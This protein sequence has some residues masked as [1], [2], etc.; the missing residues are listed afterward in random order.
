[1]R[2]S[3]REAPRAH[4]RATLF[5]VPLLRRVRRQFRPIGGSHRGARNP[6]TTAIRDWGKSR[7]KMLLF[8]TVAKIC[9]PCLPG[10]FEAAILIPNWDRRDKSERPDTVRQVGSQIEKKQ[11]GPKTGEPSMAASE[12]VHS[13]DTLQISSHPL[14]S[15]RRGRCEPANS[16]APTICSVLR[17]N[18]TPSRKSGAP[19]AHWRWRR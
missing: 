16:A 9:N 10:E 2:Q 7:V 19:L 18:E 3:R 6:R 11:G 8:A 15:R 13:P 17:A 5:M 4:F 14:D 12:D 1:M